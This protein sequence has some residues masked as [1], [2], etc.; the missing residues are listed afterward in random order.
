M[1]QI[2][3][4]IAEGLWTKEAQP[5][6][7]G[8]RLPSGKIVFPFPQGDAA[9]DAVPYPLSRTG[10]LWS[11]TRQD[12]QPKE[13]YEGPEPFKPYLLGYVEL[14]GEV[15]VETRIV[16]AVLEDLELGMAME[17]VVAPFDASRSTYAYRPE[18]RS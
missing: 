7:L 4:P 17:F 9:C 11:W 2:L 10:K 18:K 1:S 12:F 13:P 6:L 8:A 15:I 5:R 3:Q 16:D 14:P